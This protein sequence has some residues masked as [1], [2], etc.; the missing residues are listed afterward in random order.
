[1][2]IF[3]MDLAITLGLMSRSRVWVIWKLIGLIF[4]TIGYAGRL[5][6]HQDAWN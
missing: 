5:M 2:A 4:E 1:L 6:M 3:A